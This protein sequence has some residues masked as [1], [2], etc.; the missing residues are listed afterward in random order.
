MSVPG[1]WSD[2]VLFDQ[3]DTDR[4][5]SSCSVFRGDVEMGMVNGK[6]KVFQ[7]ISYQ[8]QIVEGKNYKILVN[9]GLDQRVSMIVS[10]PLGSTGQ[11]TGN[12][13]PKLLIAGWEK[14]LTQ[15]KK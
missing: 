11:A 6:F 12:V 2:P 10:W 14:D 3:T 8:T 5:R 1:G 15:T 4:A 13:T 9:V 7:P